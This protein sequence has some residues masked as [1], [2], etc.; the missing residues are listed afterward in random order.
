M[1]KVNKNNMMEKSQYVSKY[2]F[3][4]QGV[5]LSEAQSRKHNSANNLEDIKRIEHCIRTP[6]QR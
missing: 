3:Q 4:E 6:G 1:W 5:T 2:V